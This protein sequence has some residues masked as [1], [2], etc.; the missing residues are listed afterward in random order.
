MRVLFLDLETSGFDPREGEILE[1]FAQSYHV[2]NS[3][4]GGAPFHAI[5]NW[6][7]NVL[8]KI[9]S[10]H[11]VT[12]LKEDCRKSTLQWSEFV[13]KFNQF[14]NRDFGDLAAIRLAGF[15]PQFDYSW[16]KAKLEGTGPNRFSHR[17]LDV[18]TIR[19]WLGA[20]GQ[21]S[22]LPDSSKDA[23]RHRAREDVE[24]AIKTL[25][26]ARVAVRGR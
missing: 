16:L 13:T 22:T 2:G 18:S 11:A 24:V 4:R 10:Q 5:I 15:S 12:G 17:L 1:V 23:M 3:A 21:A 6:P 26:M 19:D 25:E 20:I 14:L 9:W 7:E 8:E